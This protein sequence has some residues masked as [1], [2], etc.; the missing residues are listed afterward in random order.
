MFGCLDSLSQ[1]SSFGKATRMGILMYK[2]WHSW[3]LKLFSLT[4][5]WVAPFVDQDKLALCCTGVDKCLCCK[6]PK[7]LCSASDWPN[8]RY[9]P[10]NWVQ[11]RW[12]KLRD[13]SEKDG[14]QRS[15]GNKART[16]LIKQICKTQP[17]YSKNETTMICISL[18][19][20][21]CC[22]FTMMAMTWK[23]FIW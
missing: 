22:P 12:Q 20:L 17:R 3:G 19:I 4:V 16:N 9:Q 15:E 11:V 14:S 21:E 8:N 2:R 1:V 18:S 13:Q 7:L 23:A 10:P 6:I 5:H